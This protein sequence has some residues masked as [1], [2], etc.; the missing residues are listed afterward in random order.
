[1]GNLKDFGLGAAHGSDPGGIS[2]RNFLRSSAVAAAGVAAV[3]AILPA[4]REISDLPS[5]EQFLQKH[6]K[7]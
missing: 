7:E 5:M 6:Y 2:R 1:M 4:L 3:A